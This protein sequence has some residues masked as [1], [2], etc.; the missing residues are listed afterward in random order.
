MPDGPGTGEGGDAAGM[1]SEGVVGSPKSKMGGEVSGSASELPPSAMRDG[2]GEGRRG[3][4]RAETDGPGGE[5]GM[6]SRS[7]V[8]ESASTVG[9]GRTW[10]NRRY[11]AMGSQPAAGSAGL[12]WEALTLVVKPCL[13]WPPSGTK[14]R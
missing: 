9:G 2:V 13:P 7:S 4:S 14:T 6:W 1:C 10:R 3:T 5:S 8:C 12:R 11:C